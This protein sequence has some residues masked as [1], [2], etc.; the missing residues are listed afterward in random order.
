MARI[1]LNTRASRVTIVDNIL[2][3]PAEVKADEAL[4][5]VVNPSKTIIR[6]RPVAPGIPSQHERIMS[7]RATRKLIAA[8]VLIWGERVPEPVDA[9]D[10]ADAD[11]DADDAPKAPPKQDDAAAAKTA[12]TKSAEADARREAAFTTGKG[13]GKGGRGQGKADPEPKAPADWEPT[14]KSDAPGKPDVAKA[15]PAKTD[16]A[17]GG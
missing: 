15:D 17:A 5:K 2:L 8:R 11:D 14:D 13:G 6:E 10:A 12:A 9:A 16:P 3:L 7:C 4:G 1:L